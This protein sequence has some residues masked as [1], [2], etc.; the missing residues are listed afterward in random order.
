MGDILGDALKEE[1]EEK[2]PMILKI[3]DFVSVTE[4][5]AAAFVSVFLLKS[6]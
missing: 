5:K 1:V 4:M 6:D 3:I 2:Q